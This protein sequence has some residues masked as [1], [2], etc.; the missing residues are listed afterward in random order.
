MSTLQFDRPSSLLIL[1]ATDGT[2]IGTW[3]AANFVDSRSNGPW[4]SGTYSFL[5]YLPHPEDDA[6]SAYGSNGIFIF[7]VPNRDGMGVHSGRATIPD[8]LGR[9]GYQH[10]TEGC[11]RTV[12]TA[13]A[14]LR[15]TRGIDPILTIS[16][17]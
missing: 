3:N 15:R 9:V 16:V 17:N 2:L 12:D 10:C 11:I 8:G 13:T 14:Q 1:S 4:P 5:Y 6:E 7:R